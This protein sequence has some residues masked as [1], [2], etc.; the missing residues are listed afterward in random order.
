MKRKKPNKIQLDT[1]AVWGGAIIL[2]VLSWIGL[3]KLITLIK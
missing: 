2:S 3:W 1:L